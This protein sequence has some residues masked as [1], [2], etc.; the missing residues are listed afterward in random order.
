MQR[1]LANSTTLKKYSDTITKNTSTGQD[2][3]F[4]KPDRTKVS[5]MMDQNYYNKLNEKGYVPPET[6]ITSGDVIIGK[7]S[8]IQA[9]SSTNKLFKDES[10]IFKSTV[11]GTINKVYTGIYN[12]EGY[13]MY[14]ISVRSE[15]KPMIGDKLCCYDDSH[16]I[17]TSD[18]WI[19]IKDVTTK[20]KVACLKD[21]NTLIYE[22]P[23]EVMS[24][25]YNGKMYHV[26]TTQIDLLVTPNHD[27]WVSG[28]KTDYK[29]ERAENIYGKRKFH[30]KNIESI[31]VEK[32]NEFFD[33]DEKNQITHFKIN[34]L[35]LPIN[36]WLEFFGIWLAEG[37]IGKERDQIFF[38]AHKQRVKDKLTEICAIM[39][40]D[41]KKAKNYLTDTVK[42][43]WYINDSKIA[44]Y[45]RQYSI[46]SINKYLPSWV[47]N[48]ETLLCRKLINGMLLGDGCKNGNTDRYDTSSIHLANDFQRLCLHAGWSCNIMLKGKKGECA[49]IKSGYNKGK[50][51][52]RTVDG[53][54]MS[55]VRT[56]NEPQVNKEIQHGKQQDEY[57]DF[58]GKVYCCSMPYLGVLY[59]RRN[60]VPIFCGN[61][62]HGQKGT[63][64]ILLDAT[65]MP[66]AE[67]GIQPDIIINPCCIPSEM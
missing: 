48:L 37:Y 58:V 62:R 32:N 29:K 59:V 45:M 55:I 61:S 64:G 66:F 11:Q 35:N 28:L 50:K 27:M 2:D 3:V 40:L 49:V 33:Y 44:Q 36:E 16:E 46:G 42:Q 23:T 4:M 12:S 25:D 7:A 67:S 1:G 56:R 65:D 22:N 38:A 5:G 63:V 47:W 60:Y 17:L 15:R 51:I 14:N 6:P 30:K 13:E 8:P 21:Q 26:K 54:V 43:V 34:D 41:I 9:G 39:N 53:Y 20:H 31:E 10:T 19:K 57:V 18:G 52:T 24:Y